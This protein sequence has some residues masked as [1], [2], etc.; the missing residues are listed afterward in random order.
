MV[1]PL[2]LM[3]FDRTCLSERPVG[4]SH[5]W[6]L[7]GRLYRALERLDGVHGAASWQEALAWLATFG[8]PAPLAEIQ[9]WGHGKWGQARIAEQVLDAGSL[10]PGAIEPLLCAVRNRLVPGEA[11]WWFRTCET[12]GAAAG[13]A[14]AR[15]WSAF[16]DC[17]V[18]GH[19]FI[20]GFHQSGLHSLWPGQEPTWPL[21]EGLRAG[22]PDAPVEARWSRPWAPNTITCLHGSVPEGY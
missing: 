10:E 8:A 6:R 2:R 13:H 5:V 15:A 20:I 11:L 22:T 19:T 21:D 16:F 9:F 18:A 1:A 14:F 12:L 4:L 3:V 17:R 7:G